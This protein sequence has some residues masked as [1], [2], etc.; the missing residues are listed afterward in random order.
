METRCSRF[1]KKA[2]DSKALQNKITFTKLTRL[3]Q[4][5]YIEFPRVFFSP[6]WN[7]ILKLNCFIAQKSMEKW[8]I[9][10]ASDKKWLRRKKYE[11]II[12]RKSDKWLFISRDIF[13]EWQFYWCLAF[14]LVLLKI[15]CFYHVAWGIDVWIEL[16]ILYPSSLTNTSLIMKRISTKNSNYQLK[17]LLSFLINY[18]RIPLLKI[19][20][21]FK[22]KTAS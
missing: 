22:I 15:W 20:F 6:T 18:P 5:H 8:R 19:P 4:L 16:F 9:F 2:R 13:I 12:F 7:M 3:R 21:K 11:L 10:F 17:N 1:V 14:V